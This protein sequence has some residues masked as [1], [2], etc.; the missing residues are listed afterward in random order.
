MPY[1]TYGFWLILQHNPPETPF[2]KTKENL[3]CLTIDILEE[4]E[5]KPDL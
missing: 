1:K 4:V 3:Q 5:K 2:A